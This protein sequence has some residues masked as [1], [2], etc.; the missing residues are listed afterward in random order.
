MFVRCVCWMR[1]R[2][3]VQVQEEEK[4]K[5]ED[6]PGKI[7]RPPE[8]YTAGAAYAIPSASAVGLFVSFPSKQVRADFISLDW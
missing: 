2:R 6:L 5:E 1:I 8:N 7:R 4:D 3:R